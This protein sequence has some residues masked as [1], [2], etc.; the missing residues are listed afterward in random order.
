M[1]K[2]NIVLPN[3]TKVDIE[4]T[5]DEIREILNTLGK[6]KQD[7]EV[8]PSP[9]AAEVPRGKKSFGLT[10]LITELKSNGFFKQKRSL[11]EIQERLE[12]EGYIYPTT[13]IQ[14]ILLNLLKSRVIGRVK[15]DG[16][17]KYVNR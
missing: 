16:A 13:S 15:E 7:Q 2:A 9:P 12:S 3:G 14:P 5:T 10:G 1:A 17:W 11:K 6:T 4:G 8:E